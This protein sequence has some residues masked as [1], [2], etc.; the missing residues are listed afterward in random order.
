M[1]FK[2]MALAAVIAGG[3]AVSGQAATDGTLGATSQ[4]DFDIIFSN[5]TQARIWG[6][7]DVVMS[8]TNG[9]DGTAQDMEFCVF[10]NTEDTGSNSYELSVTS[11]NGFQLVDRAGSSTDTLGYRL[12]FTDPAETHP[13]VTGNGT[14]VMT[15][16]TLS[17][18]PR[19][20]IDCANENT[21]VSVQFTGTNSSISG[22]QSGNY[23]DLITLLVTPQ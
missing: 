12:V 4:G 9:S 18:Q 19:P 20:N 21:S 17:S 2:Q 13:E 1:K 23:S 14:L 11:E 6:L 3:F 7:E 16:G 8:A 5:A 22:V 10:S 15:A